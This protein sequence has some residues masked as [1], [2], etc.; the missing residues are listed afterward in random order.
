MRVQPYSATVLALSG[1]ILMTLGLYFMFVRPPLLPEDLRFVGTS[2]A[3]VQATLPGLSVW[4]RRVFWVMGGY[5]FATGLLTTYVAVTTFRTRARG[6]GGIVAIA[7]LT[8]I[9]L[10][11]VVNFMIAS[12]FKWVIL[13]FALIWALALALYR[14][15]RTH[16]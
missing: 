1:T 2:L 7:G 14:I 16:S 5:I 15:E 3:E 10:M 12:N 8:S 4:L 9:G 13:S 11:A 6:V